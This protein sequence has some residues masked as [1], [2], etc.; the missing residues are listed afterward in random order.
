M[1]FG[2][3]I[4]GTNIRIAASERLDKPKL[5]HKVSF[6]NAPDYEENISKIVK[7][8]RSIDPSPTSVGMDMPGRF[9]Q[10]ETMVVHA[11]YVPQYVDRPI[12]EDLMKAL[13]CPVVLGHD[14]PT[15]GLGEALYG[16]HTNEDFCFLIYGTGCG[17]AFVSFKNG[18]VFASNISHEDHAI[19]LRPWQLACGG[20]GIEANY[21]KPAVELSDTEWDKV[22]SDFYEYLVAFIS[23]FKPKTI[24][25]SGG[26]ANKQWERLKEVIDRLHTERPDLPCDISLSVLGEDAGLY[27][28]LGLL[29]DRPRSSRP[30]R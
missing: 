17:G 10:K 13:N 1:Y 4:G 28:A 18:T 2:I 21:S 30:L 5:L 12:V 24:V 23:N 15:A 29:M 22:M 19:Y 16:T 27:G 26:V 9:N 11:S 25:Y 3:D 6:L 7:T 8:I 20:R 14:A